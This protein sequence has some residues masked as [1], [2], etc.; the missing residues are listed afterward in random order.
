RGHECYTLDGLD[1]KIGGRMHRLLYDEQFPQAANKLGK[2]FG[3]RVGKAEVEVPKTIGE[4]GGEE[5]G[6][7]G[8]FSAAAKAE[9]TKTEPVHTLPIT[10]KLHEAAVEQ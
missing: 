4:A 2:K 6:L 9:A 3:A 7:E 1:L 8:M 5:G 10:D